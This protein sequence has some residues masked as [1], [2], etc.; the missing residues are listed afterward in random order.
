MTGATVFLSFFELG[1]DCGFPKKCYKM[2][3]Q[4]ETALCVIVHHLSSQE[5]QAVQANHGGPAC[6]WLRA[7]QG[8]PVRP[9]VRQGRLGLG[10]Q[11]GCSSGHS[12]F[13]G[14]SPYRTKSRLE[15]NAGA[16][17]SCFFCFCLSAWKAFAARATSLKQVHTHTTKP[18]QRFQKLD[19]DSSKTAS[20]DLLLCCLA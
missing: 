6:R 16:G 18:N 1:L 15:W 12:S 3:S 20:N 19:C 2:C 9:G 14:C 10:S 13:A 8:N 5:R 4:T 11:P 7:S 17:F